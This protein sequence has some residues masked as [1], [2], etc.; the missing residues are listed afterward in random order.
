[1][2][3]PGNSSRGESEGHE[4]AEDQLHGQDHRDQDDR[5]QEIAAQGAWV[6]ASGK[7]CSV[8]GASKS[9]LVS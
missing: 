9:N 4:G 1:M 3:L 8:S 7:F 5:V 6:Q 2:F